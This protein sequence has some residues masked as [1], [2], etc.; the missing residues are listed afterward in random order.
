MVFDDT[1]APPVG[2]VEFVGG[3][4]GGECSLDK[5][6]SSSGG[7]FGFGVNIV[8]TGEVEE[9]LGDGRSN[10]SG[11]SGSR[12]KSDL[13]GSALSGDLDGNGVGSTDL[14]APISL[15]HG[16]NVELG[17]GDGTLD[18]TLNF[19]VAFPSETNVVSLVTDDGVGFEAGSLTG[20]G[21]LLNGLNLHDLFLDVVT[22]EGVNNFLL[23]DRDGESEDID[24]IFDFFALDQSSEFGDRLPFNLFFLSVG[25]LSSLFVFASSKASFS[26]LSSFS[27][28]L[29]HLGDFL[30][31]L[32]LF[33][34]NMI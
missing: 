2:S 19:L 3:F 11:S 33:S 32:W 29:F 16:D 27:S 20:L 34:H 23:L 17:H 28:F 9:L 6:S 15:S 21:L 10:Q 14:V 30:S 12:D 1:L 25:P 8:D 7:S 5:V 22:E 4:D 18:G 31:R 26:S 13:D 24:D